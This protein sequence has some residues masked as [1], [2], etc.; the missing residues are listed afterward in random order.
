MTSTISPTPA[1]PTVRLLTREHLPVVA[2]IMALVTLGAFENRAV[3]SILPSVVQHLDGWALFGASSGAPL[4]TFTIATAYA[5]GWTDRV[6]PRPVLLAGVSAF[7]LAQVTSGLAPSMGV[8]VAGR[9]L[10]GIGEALIDTALYVLIAQVLPDRLRANV[11]A[12]FAAAWVLPSLL[13][14]SAAGALDAL[15]GWRAVFVGPLLVVPLALWL[16]RTALTQ[17]HAPDAPAQDREGRARLRSGAALAAGLVGMTFTGPLVADPRMR[18]LGLALAGAGLLVLLLAGSRLLPSGTATLRT[19]LPSVVALR[20]VTSVAFTGIGGLI[21]LMLVQTHGLGPALA[22][23]SMSVTGTLWAVG[24]WLNS[25]HWAQRL[26]PS[27]RLRA[28]FLLMALGSLGPVLLALDHLGLLAGLSL[29]A[30]AALGMGVNSPTLSVEVLA[31]APSA[32]QGRAAAALGL[33]TSMGVA[34]PTG[35]GGTVVALQ[36]ASTIGPTF[37][38]LMTLGGVVAAFGALAAGRIS[39]RR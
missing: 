27:T 5:G 26:R 30:L 1:P 22:G 36:G 37:A 20:F 13:G 23:A 11:F 29:W 31:L 2:G 9:A 32:E 17:T 10:S 3:M 19:G 15:A 33:A 4:V 14:P 28:S 6:G 34:V 35:L 39:P 38:A 25:T 18:T 8:F 7:V 16:L 12:T 21:P 24:S